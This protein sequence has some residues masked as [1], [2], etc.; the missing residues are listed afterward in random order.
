MHCSLVSSHSY[1][2]GVTFIAFPDWIF[3]D[4]H[5]KLIR[6][7]F[8]THAGI[9][10]FSR[11]IVYMK[12]STNNRSTT[13]YGLF[14]EAVQSFGLPSRVRSDQG[15]ENVVVARHMIE[16]RGVDRRSM[17]T[18]SSVHNQRIERLWRDMHRCAIKFYYRL[19]YFMEDRGLFD[20]SDSQHIYTLHYVYK[21]RINKT[22]LEFRDGWN[23]HG[24][25]TAQGKT[26]HQLFTAGA[27][28]L[29]YAGIP[30]VDFF[31]DVNNTFGIDEEEDYPALVDD[32]GINIP[33]CAFVL[34]DTHFS[35]LQQEVDPLQSSDNF[36]IDLYLQALY[37]VSQIIHDNPT[38][39][40]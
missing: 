33:E 23:Q 7:G 26:P 5:H 28:E 14:L 15:R 4:G 12:C 31:E 3:V 22:L 16:C 38:I 27:L 10:G 29:R 32:S 9:D 17:I 39:Y 30:S 24:I 6:W 8:V 37:F 18:G 1:D 11:M 40:N 34:E 20:P 25:H 35:S 13:V 2:Y 21:P 36:G 19:F